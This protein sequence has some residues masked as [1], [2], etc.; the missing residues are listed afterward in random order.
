MW[1]LSTNVS[2]IITL[3]TDLL[4]QRHSVDFKDIHSLSYMLLFIIQG[5]VFLQK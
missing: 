2:R 5:L 4:N 3:I 1:L